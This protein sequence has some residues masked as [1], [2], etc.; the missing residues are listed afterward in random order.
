MTCNALPL[1]VHGSQLDRPEN[2]EENSDDR[3]NDAGRASLWP[4][5]GNRLAGL[6]PGRVEF[7]WVVWRIA[8]LVGS[9]VPAASESVFD[10]LSAF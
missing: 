9:A 3:E 1:G 10:A 5:A 4:S 6:S 2:D 8:V 7:H